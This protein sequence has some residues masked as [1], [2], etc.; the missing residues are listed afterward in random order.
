MSLGFWKIAVEHTIF[1]YNR[2]P[3]KRANWKP[4]IT[5]WDKTIPDISCFCIFG[6][7]AYIHVHKD[8]HN[9]L[10]P[11][12]KECV[13]VGYADINGSKGYR[14]WLGNNQIIESCDVTFN[15]SP[16]IAKQCLVPNRNLT[17]SETDPDDMELVTPSSPLSSPSYQPRNDP[18]SD[19]E[20]QA[21]LPPPGPPPSDSSSDDNS[22]PPPKDTSNKEKDQDGNKNPH[23]IPPTSPKTPVRPK[24]KIHQ[25]P[26]PSPK[27]KWGEATCRSTCSGA[28]QNPYCTENSTYGNVPGSQVDRDVTNTGDYVPPTTENNE[29]QLNF[30]GDI[31]INSCQAMLSHAHTSVP[32]QYWDTL[33]SPDRKKWEVACKEEYNS[34][35]QMGTWDKTLVTLPKGRKAIKC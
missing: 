1:V 35:I 23:F 33:K 17:L 18:D 16:F 13:F 8:K 12:A 28:G 4:P 3:I 19:N 6:C 32:N 5:L 15:E 20:S 14:L 21:G 10:Q 27:V 26:A 31:N 9:K 7:K 29:E 30:I 24:P 11:K 22:D 34:L 25:P 2:T